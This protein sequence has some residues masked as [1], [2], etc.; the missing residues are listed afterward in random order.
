MRPINA[1]YVLEMIDNAKNQCGN[2]KYL[3]WDTL[4]H[5]IE[6]IETLDVVPV[7]YGKWIE[8]IDHVHCSVCLDECWADSASTY[9]YCPNCGSKM[10]VGDDYKIG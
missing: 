2:N 7:R 4:R 9:N 3:N 6:N 10:L 8:C 5:A 1:D